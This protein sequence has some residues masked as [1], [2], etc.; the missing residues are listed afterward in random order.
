MNLPPMLMQLGIKH[1]KKYIRLWIPLF[2]V[3]LLILPFIVLLAPFV[4]LT[5]IIL[6]PFGWGRPILY[7]GPAVFN[8]LCALRGLKV[9][10]KENKQILL[11]S[12][13]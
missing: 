3:F 8:C 13:I 7:G 12:F 10:I 9:D 5:T 1:E 11:I 6:W 2:I 4:L